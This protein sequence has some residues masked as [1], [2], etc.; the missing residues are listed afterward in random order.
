M[1]KIACRVCGSDFFNSTISLELLPICNQFSTNEHE[2]I[3]FHPLTLTAC[4]DC[5][6]IQLISF[7]SRELVV[8][9]V[10]WIKYNEPVEHLRRFVE[11]IYKNSCVSTVLGLGPFD[12]PLLEIMAEYGSEIQI[13]NLI[14]PQ[15]KDSMYFPYL[16]TIQHIITTEPLVEIYGKSDYVVCRFIIE[17]CHDPLKALKNLRQLINDKGFLIIEVPDSTKFLVNKDYSFIWEE[18][19]LYFTESSIRNF[20]EASD[21]EI[22]LFFKNPGQLEDNIILLLKP[23]SEQSKTI[24]LTKPS[25]IELNLFA[26]YCDSFNTIKN[27]YVYKLS[28]ITASGGTIALFGAGHQAIMF[29]NAFCLQRFISK[30]ID[31]DPNKQGYTVPGTKIKIASTSNLLQ[32]ESIQVCLLAV[33][34]KIEKLIQDKLAPLT[35]KGVKIYSIF[36]G[37]HLPLIIEG[38]N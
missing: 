6:V 3:N 1:T 5:G 35:Q 25:A 34:P 17:H 37:S 12:Q 13:A 9:R 33:S 19:I 27:S 38:C 21:F 4:N 11:T 15:N 29:L 32:D 14:P 2:T 7:A 36:P 10:C 24:S 16:E 8:P 31:D 23:K 28:K 22:E 18:H 20:I 30:I 26:G